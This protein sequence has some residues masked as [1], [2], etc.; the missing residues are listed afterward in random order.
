MPSFATAGHIYLLFLFLCSH[1]RT[2]C[3]G[4][5]PSSNFF[6]NALKK[7]VDEFKEKMTR[8]SKVTIRE[9]TS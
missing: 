1:L 9:C 8:A 3:G 7:E 4:E 5:Q 2:S 6:D